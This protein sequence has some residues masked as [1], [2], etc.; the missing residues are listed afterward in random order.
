MR[1]FLT[2]AGVVVALLLVAFVAFY[3]W[4]SSAVYP[5]A[6]Y[7]QVKEYGAAPEITLPDTLTVATYNIG[8]LSGMTNNLPQQR[9]PEL[10]A[11]NLHS[12]REVLRR[13]RADVIGFQEIDFAAARSFDYQQMDS[14]AESNDYAFGAMAVNWDARYVPF[15]FG[16][17]NV[18]FGRILSGQAI[19]SR[20]QISVH[21]R[22]VLERPPNPF[23]Y[24][25][26]YLDRLAQVAY[27]E[28]DPAIAVINVHFEAFDRGTR[29]LH[30][31]AVAEL[32]DSLAEDYAILLIGDFNAIPDRYWSP[33]VGDAEEMDRRE[34]DRTTDFLEAI[35]VL[36]PVY[37]DDLYEEGQ[38][39]TFPAD[40]PGI[41]IDHIYYDRRYFRAVDADVLDADGP[42]SDHRP[43]VAKLVLQEARPT[44]MPGD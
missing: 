23:W 4:A 8:Y 26:F 22:V 40:D 27:L 5:A 20:F 11:D 1:T 6:T 43:V 15:P 21:E 39:N 7:L 41:K 17:P 16:S 12:A 30:G 18:Y 29:E 19:L 31:R 35:D 3:F 28:T 37:A 10:F 24:N 25:A 34:G 32:V 36:R 14:L 42:P 44:E 9:T 13:L 38:V 2:R 33:G